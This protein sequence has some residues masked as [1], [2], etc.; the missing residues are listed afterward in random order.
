MKTN[1]QFN[2]QQL[3]RQT[4]HFELHSSDLVAH[5]LNECIT[6]RNKV[7]GKPV[8]LPLWLGLPNYFK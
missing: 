5:R 3:D 7:I 6:G 2:H 8:D 4:Q 1:E